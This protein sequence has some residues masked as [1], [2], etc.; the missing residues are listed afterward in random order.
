M[1]RAILSVNAIACTIT[2]CAAGCGPRHDA[3]TL[4]FLAGE[5]RAHPLAVARVIP[6]LHGPERECDRQGRLLV[7][8]SEP[9]GIRWPLHR[10]AGLAR[11]TVLDR[12]VSLVARCSVSCPTGHRRSTRDPVDEH[13]SS[14][15]A[16]VGRHPGYQR[17]PRARWKC[18]AVVRGQL[19]ENAA[20][21]PM[22]F[23]VAVA[24]G[25]LLLL[26]LNGRARETSARSRTGTTS[27]MTGRRIH[28]AKGTY[29]GSLP[30]DDPIFIEGPRSY[31]PH[32]ARAYLA[33]RPTSPGATAGPQTAKDGSGSS[34]PCSKPKS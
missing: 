3:A 24:T 11:V 22:G 32:W 10:R 28:L 20:V 34:P 30:P 17:E 6:A 14:A 13:D 7:S 2:K 1:L 23:I 4:T 25:K 15:A 27:P 21:L 8:F 12:W 19:A 16:M 33:S 9:D 31:S 29:L 26:S 18:S 5:A